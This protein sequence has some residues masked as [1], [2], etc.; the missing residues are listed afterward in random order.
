MAAWSYLFSWVCGQEFSLE[1][2]VGMVR[3][4]VDRIGMMLPATGEERREQHKS[5]RL[6]LAGKKKST[7]NSIAE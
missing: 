6:V 7:C 2:S 3:T 1:E 5:R 4:V